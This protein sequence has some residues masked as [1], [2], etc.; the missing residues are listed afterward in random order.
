MKMTYSE[1]SVVG[2]L[3]KISVCGPFSMFCKLIHLWKDLL[4]PVEVSVAVA[5]VYGPIGPFGAPPSKCWS[6][7]GG[8]RF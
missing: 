3:R 2:R 7:A 8:T 5:S 1:L 4:S 6:P